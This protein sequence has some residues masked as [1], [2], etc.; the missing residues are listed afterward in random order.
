VEAKGVA[1]FS[2]VSPGYLVGLPLIIAADLYFGPL[3]PKNCLPHPIWS[4]FGETN[5]I[6]KICQPIHLFLMRWVPSKRATFSSG[7]A[8]RQQ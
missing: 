2:R 3:K 4:Q 6:V 1:A 8:R 7:W 5:H